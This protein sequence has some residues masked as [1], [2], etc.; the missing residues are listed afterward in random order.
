MI[1][2]IAAEKIRSL[3]T[4]FK[5]VA[6][7]G[8][9]QSGKTTLARACFPD[10]AY[11]SLEDPDVRAYALED[12][13]SFLEQYQVGAIFDE[14][15][16]VPE[17]PSYLQTKLDSS[18]ENGKFILTGSNNFLLQEQISQSLAGRAAYLDLLPF[19]MSELQDIPGGLD[20]LNTLLFKGSY[21]AI[22]AKHIAPADWFGAYIRTYV[23]RDVRQIR[24]IGNLLLFEKMLSLCAGRIGQLLNYSNLANEVG[25]D[26]KTI[27]AWLGLLQASYHIFLLPP[28]YQNFNKRIVKTPKLY[29]YDTGLASYLLR[30]TDPAQLY[31][32]PYR[33][34]LFENFVITEMLKERYNQGLRSNLYFWRD[35]TG[36][37]VDV[38]V[39]EGIH[40]KAYEIKSSATIDKNHFK[41][42]RFWQKTTGSETGHL[43]YAGTEA[44]RRSGFEL[45]PWRS[46]KTL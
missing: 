34:A 14:I 38:I 15:Q 21:P 37:E 11:V 19:S 18:E 17:L 35:R 24:N 45:I 29:F 41:N 5:A 9:R 10:K 30:I 20:D 36:N 2:R 8:P 25:V 22:Q 43:I 13:R 7:I 44:Q 6:I 23:E 32:H 33:G 28:Y 46:L 4:K 26:Y 40:Q 12:P 42:L 31:Q 39:D 3:A 27:Q 16:R 1:A